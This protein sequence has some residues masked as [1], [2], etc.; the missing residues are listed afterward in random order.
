MCGKAEASANGS[1]LYT[2]TGT[3]VAS[4]AAN[5]G[6]TRSMPFKIEAPCEP[7]GAGRPV[8]SRT[9]VEE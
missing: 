4:D 5:P 1:S 3:A 9:A 2:I 7:S 6:Q 8:A